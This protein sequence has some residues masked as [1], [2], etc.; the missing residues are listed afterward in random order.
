MSYMGGHR[1][2][3]VLWYSYWRTHPHADPYTEK[4]YID[5]NSHINCGNDKKNQRFSNNKFGSCNS[6]RNY[7]KPI[8]IQSNI[9]VFH[10]IH[11]S[12]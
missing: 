5:N 2:G 3:N 12:S 1:C 9:Q 10:R 7:L 4:V 6:Y 8:I 11:L